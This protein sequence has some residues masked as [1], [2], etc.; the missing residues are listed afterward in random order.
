MDSIFLKK[1]GST[2]NIEERPKYSEIKKTICKS[3]TKIVEERKL[4]SNRR[5]T[6]APGAFKSAH[7]KMERQTS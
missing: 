6:F 5:M 3:P 4:P 7:I 2:Q 1:C